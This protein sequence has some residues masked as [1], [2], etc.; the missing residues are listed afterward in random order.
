MMMLVSGIEIEMK[1][2][3]MYTYVETHGQPDSSIMVYGCITKPDQPEVWVGLMDY[4]FGMEQCM[5]SPY[6]SGFYQFDH[7]CHVS[8][9]VVVC[10]KVYADFLTFIPA[11]SHINVLYPFLEPDL[12]ALDVHNHVYTA[13]LSGTT[14]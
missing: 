7:T 1:L 10:K 12:G 11:Y 9:L 8:K 14:F 3:E 13:I 5:Y 4:Y 6:V 2:N